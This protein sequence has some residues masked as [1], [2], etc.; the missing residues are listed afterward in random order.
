MRK[1][2][3]A[4]SMVIQ[5]EKQDSPHKDWEEDGK[6]ENGRIQTTSQTFGENKQHIEGK[7]KT[8]KHNT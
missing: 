4:D 7:M 8:I 3:L 2:T 6:R 5:K 1:E